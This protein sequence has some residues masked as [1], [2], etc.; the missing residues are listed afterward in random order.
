MHGL[1]QTLDLMFLLLPVPGALLLRQILHLEAG[2][3]MP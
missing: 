2:Q 3:R 1:H